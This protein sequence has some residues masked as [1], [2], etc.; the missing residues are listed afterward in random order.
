M[1]LDQNFLMTS[2][3]SVSVKLY[4]RFQAFE[5]ITWLW[6]L[7]RRAEPAHPRKFFKI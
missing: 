5:V 6:R 7:W 2:L 3:T 1:R 4:P